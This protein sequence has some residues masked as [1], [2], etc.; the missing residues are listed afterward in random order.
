MMG[1]ERYRVIPKEQ[2]EYYMAPKEDSSV[3]IMFEEIVQRP[4]H[5]QDQDYQ[6]DFVADLDHHSQKPFSVAQK[7]AYKQGSNYITPREY[8]APGEEMILFEQ[9][10]KRSENYHQQVSAGH[11]G[12]YLHTTVVR[13]EQHKFVRESIIQQQDCN[14]YGRVTNKSVGTL[15]CS[16]AATLYYGMVLKE[17]GGNTN[18]PHRDVARDYGRKNKFPPKFKQ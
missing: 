14:N 4:D 6:Q 17:Y 7:G 3:P 13:Q 1:E 2:D 10:G 15:D 5:D 18:F 9:S 12:P 8:M 11:G 16:E